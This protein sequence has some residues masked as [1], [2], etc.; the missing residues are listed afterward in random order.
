MGSCQL[1]SG[2]Q[3]P[4]TLKRRQRDPFYLICFR[5]PNPKKPGEMARLEKTSKAAN[6]KRAEEAAPAI[7]RKAYGI[8]ERRFIEWDGEEGAIEK[9]N[10]ECEAAN[11]RPGTVDQYRIAIRNLRKVFPESKGPADITPENAAEFKKRRTK[12]K[13]SKRTVAG[14]ITN[15]NIVFGRWF[16][17]SCKIID[18]NPFAEVEPPKLDKP[19]IRVIAADED[20]AFRDWL[21]K[22]WPGWRLP[23][24]FLDVKAA[25]GCRINELASLPTASLQDGR[26]V[27]QA[28]DTKSREQR[29]PKP[30]AALF[31]E[32]KA[33]AGP[34]YAFEHFADELKEHSDAYRVKEFKPLR[35]IRWLQR[36][37]RTYFEA[38][39]AKPFKLHNYRGSAMS[40][41]R[42]RGIPYDDA[43]IAFGCNPET[44]RKHYVQ[45]DNQAISDSV[46]E[47]LNGGGSG[48]KSK[49]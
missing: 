5:G 18:T 26:L 42:L 2:E 7:I 28:A 17:D 34:T 47:I 39:G 12:A 33:Q 10:T 38:T 22:C 4:F 14:N 31:A 45:T 37:A 40:K 3:I 36:Q 19:K 25:I 35:L 41:A 43:A 16:R 29:S 49:P 32:L 48:E 20:K 23:L 24:L 6:K 44:M 46:F 21:A 15:L 8:V 9:L 30:P 13:R 1:P 27:F 11:L